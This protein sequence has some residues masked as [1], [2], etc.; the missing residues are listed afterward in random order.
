MWSTLP[1]EINDSNTLSEFNQKKTMG[2]KFLHLQIV[3]DFCERF[4]VFINIFNFLKIVNRVK[5][6]GVN[7]N[8]N[9]TNFDNTL[10]YNCRP[11]LVR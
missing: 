4:R 3:Q 10:K 11:R 7:N 2:R 9:N 5:F 6:F 8:I 1:Q